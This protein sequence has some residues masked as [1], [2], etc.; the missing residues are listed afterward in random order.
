ML[1]TTLAGGGNITEVHRQ[2]AGT[3]QKYIGR[4]RVHNRSTKKVHYMS[5]KNITKKY[6]LNVNKKSNKIFGFCQQSK[7]LCLLVVDG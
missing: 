7:K 5:K 3:Q 6:I 1:K 4:R 2:E